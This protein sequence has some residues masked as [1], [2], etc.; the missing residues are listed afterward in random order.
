MIT[1]TRFD[2]LPARWPRA[3]L[4]RVWLRQQDRLAAMIPGARHVSVDTRSYDMWTLDPFPVLEGIN[5]VV[6]AAR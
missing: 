5:A 2:D 3:R 4:K 1:A 6:R